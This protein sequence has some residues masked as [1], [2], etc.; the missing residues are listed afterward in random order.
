MEKVKKIKIKKIVIF[1]NFFNFKKI[2]FVN[3]NI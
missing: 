1:S 3:N 2:F